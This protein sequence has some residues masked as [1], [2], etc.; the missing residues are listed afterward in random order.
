M[1]AAADRNLLLGILALQTGLISRDALVAAMQAWLL[2]RQVP[3]EEHLVRLGGLTGEHRALLTPLVEAHIRQHGGDPQRS[4]AALDSIG[5]AR[6]ALEQIQDETLQA[7]LSLVSHS[8]TMDAGDP[9]ATMTGAPP[10]KAVGTRFRIIRPH[11]EGGL[12]QVFLAR[13]EEVGRDVALKEIKPRWADDRDSRA[14]FLREAEIT[15][16]LEHPGIVPVYGLGAYADGRPFYAMRFVRG[17]SLKEAIEAFTRREGLTATERNLEMRRLLQRLIDVCEAIDYAHSRGVL[18]RDLKPGNIMLGRYGETLVVDWGLAKALGKSAA[19]QARIDTAATTETP[20]IP[21]SSDSEP[22]HVG[23]AIGTPAFMSPEQAQGQLEALGPSSDVFSLGATLYQLLTGVPPYSG[24]DLLRRAQLARYERPRQV[25]SEIPRPLEAI[26]LKAMAAAPRERYAS[27]GE[28][29]SEIERWL[30]GEPVTAYPER[31]HER[32]AR[33][34]RRH[35]AWFTAGAMALTLITIVSTVALIIVS[36]QNKAIRRLASAEKSARTE[37][38]L[39]RKEAETAR[40]DQAKARREAQ[41]ARDQASRDRARLGEIVDQLGAQAY[42]NRRHRPLLESAVANYR[43]ILGRDE[44]ILAGPP[45][46][47]DNSVSAP[48]ASDAV[49]SAQVP[50]G[51]HTTRSAGSAEVTG[52]TQHSPLVASN[53]TIDVEAE[54]DRAGDD[55]LLRARFQAKLATLLE[56]L[57][58][59]P[60]AKAA[61]QAAIAEYQSL[62]TQVP[63]PQRRRVRFELASTYGNLGAMYVQTPETLAGLS[64]LD[65][66][67]EIQGELASEELSSPDDR[68]ELARHRFNRGHIRAILAI[69]GAS[70]DLLAA[71]ELQQTLVDEDDKSPA[72]R[73]ELSVMQIELGTR[74]AQ[75]AH[76]AVARAGLLN[77]AARQQAQQKLRTARE[78]IESAVA[79]LEALLAKQSQNSEYR[80]ELADGQAELGQAQALE[81]N[82]TAAEASLGKSI[83][84][85]TRLL[86]DFPSDP[87][88]QRGLGLA[89]FSQALVKDLGSDGDEAAATYLAAAEIQERLTASYPDRALYFVDAAKTWTNLAALQ[90]KR[91][92]LEDALRSIKTAVNKFHAAWKLERY[93]ERMRPAVYQSYIGLAQIAIAAG[94][95]ASLAELGQSHAN[96]VP[97]R[98]ADLF[99]AAKLTALAVPLAARDAKLSADLQRETSE[100]YA[101]Q[102]MELLRRAHAKGMRDAKAVRDEPD[103]APL[104]TRA[105]FEELLKSMEAT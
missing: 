93:D 75:Q 23:A 34:V 77:V 96:L 17:T 36:F 71:V 54:I 86:A 42:R 31:V 95:H 9:Y 70:D 3:L 76:A 101:R 47:A 15:G 104:R 30:A 92:N 16:G 82:L 11:A 72:L 66:A 13:D 78:Q 39:K 38:E 24:E 59:Y 57:D 19:E 12:G 60:G 46:L 40:D 22:T 105:D 73:L 5:S 2:A 87:D 91:R 20:L 50:A 63:Q 29:A 58:D 85:F 55:P 8:D 35:R 53:E 41:L 61:Y 98:A 10:S 45:L 94:D 6:Q 27:A 32:A 28:L 89:R 67:I 102:A 99:D 62:L 79:A 74:L 43:D 100:I 44:P 69:D 103:L 97:D 48:P 21:A 26:C 25:R 68:R 7:T 18:H 49:F 51:S 14:R 33:W 4:L 80:K 81:G 83:E 56:S 52:D 90:F 65:K 1:N 88:F 64:A 84:G 37:A